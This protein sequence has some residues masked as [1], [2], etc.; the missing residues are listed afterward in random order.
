MTIKD[1]TE[2]LP[3][4][5][6]CPLYC[7]GEHGSGQLSILHGVPDIPRSKM[8]VEGLYVGGDLQL[9]RELVSSGQAMPNDFKFMLQK[10]QWTPSQ[11]E[12]EMELGIWQLASS[13][14]EVILKSESNTEMPLWREVMSLMGGIHE[15]KAR[16][17]YDEL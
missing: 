13:N 10:Q 8:I 5:Q 2:E 15:L 17:V 7:G 12:W 3:E 11:L 9:A 16:D 4:F 14:V 1:V 6:N